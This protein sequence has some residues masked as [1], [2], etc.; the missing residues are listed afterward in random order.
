MRLTGFLTRGELG[1]FN[2]ALALA[3][4]TDTMPS[5]AAVLNYRSRGGVSLDAEQQ[6]TTDVGAF[7]HAGTADGSAA[8]TDV[9]KTL[10]LGLSIAGAGWRRPD[11][12]VGLGFVENDVSANSRATWSPAASPC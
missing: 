5:T 3:A 11:D 10:S 2:N 1:S 9:D 12:T 7:L 4:R 8:F 6:L